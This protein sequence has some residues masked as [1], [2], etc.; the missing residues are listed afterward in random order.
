[1]NSMI[2]LGFQQ[3]TDWDMNSIIQ[4]VIINKQCTKLWLPG[5][6]IT[7]AGAS[8]LA[9]GLSNTNRLER[10]YLSGNCLSDK[11]VKFLA[12]ELVNNKQTLKILNLQDNAITD[13][14]VEYL[15]DMLTKNTALISLSL[16]KNRISDVGVRLMACTLEKYNNTLEHLDLSANNGITDMIVPILYQMIKCNRSLNELSIHSCNLSRK[17]KEQLRKATA[18]KQNLNV[19]VN[20]WTE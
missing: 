13:L 3:L 20:S 2:D 16:D 7:S 19:Y 17:G 14:G 8:I 15:S 11:G 4:Q 5:N 18:I 6:T 12:D 10:L 1:M 9:S